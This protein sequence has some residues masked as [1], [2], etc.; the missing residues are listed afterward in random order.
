MY[1]Q[2]IVKCTGLTYVIIHVFMKYKKNAISTVM[3]DLCMNGANRYA[4]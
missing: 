2:D 1:Q 4:V 3:Y